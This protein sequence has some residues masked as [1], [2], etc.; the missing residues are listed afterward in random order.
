MSCK[1]NSYHS[2]IVILLVHELLTSVGGETH[3]HTVTLRLNT[4]FVVL[5]SQDSYMY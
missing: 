2:N 3:I 5:S 1:L 4:S